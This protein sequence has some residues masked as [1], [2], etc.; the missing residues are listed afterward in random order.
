MIIM[1]YFCEIL[2]VFTIF[3]CASIMT[4]NNSIDSMLKNF[5]IQTLLISFYILHIFFKYGKQSHSFIVLLLPHVVFIFLIFSVRIFLWPKFITQLIPN[6]LPYGKAVHRHWIFISSILFYSFIF[7][8]S[9]HVTSPLKENKFI[10]TQ[11]LLLLR[12]NLSLGL[13]IIISA[14]FVMV[15]R[16]DILSQTIGLIQ[17]ENGL[18]FTV[19]SLSLFFIK[20]FYYL[21]IAAFVFMFLTLIILYFLLK[22]IK[23]EIGSFETTKI[24]NL[25]G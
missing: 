22:N 10:G 16:N 1:Y 23:S 21:L 13:V 14:I 15:T 12:I 2:F 17:A 19:F 25:K 6:M 5:T 4:I 9:F 8:I 24:E 18:Y 3:C 7:Y 20:F 11:E